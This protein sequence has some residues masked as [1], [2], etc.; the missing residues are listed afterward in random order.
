M[1]LLKTNRL[2]FK[3]YAYKV[4]CNLP[5]ADLVRR[6]NAAELAHLFSLPYKPTII[7]YR[8]L[9][10]D[11]KNSIVEFRTAVDPWLHKDQKTRIEMNL[12]N[13]YFDNEVECDK[14]VA[15]V[16]K[17]I[18]KVTKPDS[19]KD[20]D[21][22][23]SKNF[24]SVCDKLPHRKFQYKIMLSNSM[25]DD[26]REKFI[27]WAEM[28]TDKFEI[29][30]KTLRWLKGKTTYCYEPFLYVESSKEL[31]LVNL[32]ISQHIRRTYEFVLRDTAINTVSEDKVCQP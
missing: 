25:P 27:T 29:P 21:L 23:Q 1:K 26:T 11:N 20:L 12:F 16:G 8:T 6:Y 2:F 28:Y 32:Y 19:A 9:T 4:E 15:A 30:G 17:F 3:K 7:K 5:G 18:S 31:T 14:F 10:A 24:I 13:F 22:L